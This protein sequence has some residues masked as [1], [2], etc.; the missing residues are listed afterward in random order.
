MHELSRLFREPVGI[1]FWVVLLTALMAMRGPVLLI[2]NNVVNCC[3]TICPKVRWRMTWMNSKPFSRNKLSK[4]IIMTY[5]QKSLLK[6][7][8]LVLKF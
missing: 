6:V 7:N 4:G 2:T 1:I 5:L 8:I 3:R